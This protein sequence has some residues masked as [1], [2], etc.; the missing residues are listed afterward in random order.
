MA[1]LIPVEW[2]VT[3]NIKYKHGLNDLL[4]VNQRVHVS[5]MNQ[6]GIP[7]GSG[8]STSTRLSILHARPS[9]PSLLAVS[10]RFSEQFQA[11]CHTDTVSK[12]QKNE[13]QKGTRNEEDT[14]EQCLK[15]FAVP[16]MLPDPTFLF[17]FPQEHTPDAFRLYFC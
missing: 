17:H 9:L 3:E 4:K 10:Y 5:T 14:R 16:M 6:T 8:F 7:R 13:R 1:P 11:T 12:R 15:T 2:R